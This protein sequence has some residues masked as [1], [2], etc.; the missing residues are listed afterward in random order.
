MAKKVDR[1]QSTTHF[2]QIALPP[3]QACVLISWVGANCLA[4]IVLAANYA[5]LRHT[6][7]ASLVP[8]TSNYMLVYSTTH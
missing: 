6:D 1:C 7:G 3:K 2:V 8:N 4:P 5:T